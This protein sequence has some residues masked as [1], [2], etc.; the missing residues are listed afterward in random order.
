M[1]G[2][3][4]ADTF[5]QPRIG[6][7]LRIVISGLLP[8][9]IRRIADDD[10]NG[11]FLLRLYTFGVL[12]QRRGIEPVGIVRFSKLE[13]I[14]QTDAVEGR[15]GYVFVLC[16]MVCV[17]DINGRDI[18]RQKNDF[19]GVQFISVFARQ[20]FRVDESA[21]DH[22]C[23]EGP[24]AGERIEHMHVLIRQRTS[25]RGL[26]YIGHGAVD[27]IHDFHRRIHDAQLFHC[28]GEGSAEKF[29]IQLDDDALSAFG[30]VDAG[31][32][33]FHGFIEA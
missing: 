9:G 30:I 27:E 19:V 32:T 28:Q 10:L 20:G 33:H 2:I 7:I 6:L 5:F 3:G 11:R 31:N 18:I 12:R 17:F 4:D 13:S 22:A 14:R 24:R 16:C 29:V 21:L 25:E 1:R 26:Q 23:D 8:H 15:I